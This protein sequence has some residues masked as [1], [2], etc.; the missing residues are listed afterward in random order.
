MKLKFGRMIFEQ[1][2]SFPVSLRFHFSQNQFYLKAERV[3]KE[4]PNKFILQ[5]SKT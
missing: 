3:A 4:N 2:L 5:M 1:A